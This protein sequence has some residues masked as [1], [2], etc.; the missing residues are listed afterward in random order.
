MYLTGCMHEVWPAVEAIIS[1]V[2][3][4][5][6]CKFGSAPYERSTV[7]HSSDPHTQAK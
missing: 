1:G 4:R 3:R 5:L 2:S 6:S 7:V